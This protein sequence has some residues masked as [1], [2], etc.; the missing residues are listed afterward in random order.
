MELIVPVT[1]RSAPQVLP[2]SPI[3]ASA[4]HDLVQLNTKRKTCRECSLKH[5]GTDVRPGSTLMGCRQCDLPL[6][7]K[8]FM[9]HV[10]RH[11]RWLVCV[12]VRACVCSKRRDVSHGAQRLRMFPVPSQDFPHF[13][14]TSII[15]RCL[16]L[17]VGMF[18]K[19]Y[20][21]CDMLFDHIKYFSLPI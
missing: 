13:F 18:L 3:G 5:S 6:H 12:C 20:V 10:L 9:H 19:C 15:P 8:C 1:K 4:E 2:T 14:P 16:V 17:C 7:R 21:I 11:E